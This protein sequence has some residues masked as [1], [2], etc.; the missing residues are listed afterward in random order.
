MNVDQFLAE[1][2]GK[3]ISVTFIRK[4][5]SKAGA[6]AGEEVTRVF[7][8]G[9]KKGVKGV[10]QPFDREEKGLTTLWCKAGFRN[11]AKD[12]ILRLKCGEKVAEFRK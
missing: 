8:T 3:F 2:K 9:V 5:K 4:N 7:R 10:G 6:A 12:N 11:I 1:T